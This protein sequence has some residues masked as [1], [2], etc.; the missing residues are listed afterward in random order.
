MNKNEMVAILKQLELDRS[1]CEICMGSALLMYG[2]RE[3]AHDADIAVSEERFQEYLDKGYP[4]ECNTWG[5]ERILIDIDGGFEI[6]LFRETL[7]E[8]ESKYFDGF[9]VQTLE[10]IIKWKEHLGREKDLRDLKV[11]KEY[12][13]KNR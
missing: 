4:I 5:R 6:E 10:S 8:V 1:G 7:M 2:L 13:D 9:Y 11:I 3:K 12:I